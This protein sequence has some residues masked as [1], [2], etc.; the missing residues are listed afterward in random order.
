MSEKKQ[1]SPGPGRPKDPRK[2]QAILDAAQSLFLQLGYEG[3][4]MDAIASEAQVSKLTVYSHFTD[5]ETLYAAAIR[6]VCETELPQLFVEGAPADDIRQSLVRVGNGF[7]TLVNSPEYLS[8]HRLLVSMAGQDKKLAQLFYEAGPQRVCNGM[9]RLLEKACAD[10]ALQVTDPVGAA[11]HF[12]SLLKGDHNFRLLIGYEN[13][14][15]P[16]ERSQFVEEVVDLFLKAY[17]ST[18][19]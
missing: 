3:A 1:L 7:Y 18:A 16:Q 19:A 15:A 12:F 11:R 9:V 8:L 14:K 2:R 6:S 4:S 10:G 17:G 5:K 13:S